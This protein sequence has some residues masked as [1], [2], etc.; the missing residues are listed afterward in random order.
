MRWGVTAAAGYLIVLIGVVML[1]DRL[2]FRPVRAGQVWATPHDLNVQDVELRTADGTRI[3]A[4]WCPCE[5]SDGAL[6][7]CHGNAGNLS[8]RAGAIAALREALHQ[9]VLIFDY[10][11][12]GRSDGDPSE[13]GCYEAADAAYDWLTRAQQVPP[14]RLL[15]FGK[16]LGGGVA[17]DLASRRPHRALILAKTFTSM[18]ELAQH[19]CPVLPA[20]W[21]AHNRFDNLAKIPLCT[22]PVFITHGDCDSLVPFAMGERLFEAAGQPKQFF[23]MA[24]CEHNDAMS[25]G[26]FAALRRFLEEAA[27]TAPGQ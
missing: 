21:L 13:A 11:G 6:L 9:S 2:V 25:P 4:W 22:R 24:G 20:R 5:G 16:S 23:R 12:F 26:F 17:I 3:H 18:P 1:E 15:I 19:L 8:Y 7:Y 10:P 14:E 27:A